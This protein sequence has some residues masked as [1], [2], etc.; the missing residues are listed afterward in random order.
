MNLINHIYH[1]LTVLAEVP[2][3]TPAKWKCK[4]T[5]GKEV[6]VFGKHLKSGNT[7]SCGCISKYSINRNKHGQSKNRL[8]NIWR[9]MKQRC[10]NPNSTGYSMYGEK[11]IT[12]CKEWENSADFINWAFSNGYEDSLQIDRIDN[13]QGYSPANCRW[14]PQIIQMRNRNSFKNSTSKYVGVTYSPN[15]K[16]KKWK[17]SIGFDGKTKTLGWFETELEAAQA[18]DAYVKEGG[19]VGFTINI[20]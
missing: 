14:V 7:K 18:R 1:N 13:S 19:F 2:N 10:S 11:G 8:Y 20:P 12:V 4:C 16:G 9:L 5:C 15:R 6:E 3:S 17:A